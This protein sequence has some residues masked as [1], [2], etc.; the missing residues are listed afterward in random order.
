M[1]R[2]VAFTAAWIVSILLTQAAF[3]H[4]I[5]FLL[6]V[7]ASLLLYFG[8]RHERRGQLLIWALCG[9]L[10]GAGR[11]LLWQKPI[12]E[13]HIANYNGVDFAR[14]TGVVTAAPDRRTLYTNLRLSTERIGFVEGNSYP[15]HGE[16]MVKA[17]VYTP[18]RYGD[19]VQVSGALSTPPVFEG[20]SYRD[21][22]ARRGIYTLLP[23]AE[24]QVL[25]SHQANMLLD[26]LLRFREYA[27]ARLMKILPE[28]QVSLLAGILLGVE[29]GISGELNEAFSTTGT[30][31]IVAISGFNLT[32][33]AGVFALLARRL[34]GEKGETPV[35]LT[36]VWLY[37]LLVGASAAVVR[38]AVMG[39][40]AIFARRERRPLHGP[41]SL[42]LAALAMSAHDPMVLWDV[43]FQLSLA[44]TAGLIFFTD[45]LTAWFLRGL[46]RFMRAEQAERV[47]GWLSEALIV[48]LAAQITTTPIIVATF[49][50]LSL[51]T[52]LTNFLIL[53][54]QSFVMLFGGVALLAALLWLPL[55]QLLGWLA[56]AFLTYTIEMVRWTATFAWA[57]VAVPGKIWPLVVAYYLLLSV[58]LW[59]FSLRAE[60]RRDWWERWQQLP[61]WQLAGGL[62]VLLLLGAYLWT[63]PDGKLHIFFLDVGSGEA[64]FIQTP[65]GRQVV[66]NGGV[67]APTLLSRVGRRVPFWDRTLDL[68]V[69]SSPDRK[70]LPGL[71]PLLERYQVDF[72]A[73]GPEEG[74]GPHYEQWVALLNARPAETVGIFWAGSAWQLDEEVWLRALWP[75]RGATGPLVLRL[76]YGETSVLLT[77]GATTLVEELLVAR[78]AEALQSSVLQ[79]PRQGAPTGSTPA[80]LEAVDP[81]I[82]VISV[83]DDAR[84]DTPAP[85]VLARLLDLLLYRTDRQG[86]IEII[87]DGE[88][89]SVRT[90]RGERD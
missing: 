26:G 12:D 45:P 1:T 11:F 2:L 33:I 46:R 80:F 15:V 48:T 65:S 40:L 23:R 24:L 51:V 22:L 86:T 5:W 47:V 32:I 85:Q 87:S 67:D 20:F 58:A 61:H 18:V 88:R 34:F 72:V 78:D 75:E 17:P 4:P 79:I 60:E 66:L 25:E 37:T 39:S 89:V 63:M 81:E 54:V 3:F 10:L 38:A 13:G 16:L 30:S 28:P 59:W 29:S 64:V 52:L 6:T 14:V 74:A 73:S 8:W 41:T 83:E 49:H 57:S 69:L 31:H 21:Y 42:A 55:G 7:P 70:R 50:R 62:A 43:G 82:A 19:R 68:V 27:L 53:P 56:W 90:E 44:A 35:A 76:D 77:G 71:V 9:L 84:T 36:G